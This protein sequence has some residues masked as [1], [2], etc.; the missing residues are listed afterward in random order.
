MMRGHRRG[1]LVWIIAVGVVVTSA[2]AL[3]A[4]EPPP[5]APPGTSQTSSPTARS[6]EDAEHPSWLKPIPVPADPEL[7]AQL[8]ELQDALKALNE[9]IVRRKEV[10]RETNAPDA[11]TALYHEIDTLRTERDKLEALLHALVNEARASER[12]A[13]DEALERARGLERERE[14]WQRKEEAI[15][16]RQ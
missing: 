14:Y 13:I 2:G 8:V 5:A 4:K 15:R 7:E 10:L 12:T 1:R 6:T 3:Q 9:Q 11:K 16:D